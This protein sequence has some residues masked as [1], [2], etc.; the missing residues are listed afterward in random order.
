MTESVDRASGHEGQANRPTATR[1]TWTQIDWRNA[2]RNVQHLQQ[3]IFRAAQQKD[4]QKV[5]HL[6]RLLLKSHSNLVVS[7]RQI[8]Q[9]NAGKATPGVDGE[10]ALD[11]QTR[12]RLVNELS[13]TQY[14]KAKPVRR[15]YIPKAKGGKRPLGIPTIRDRI[16]QNVVK[17]AYEP[18]FETEFEANSFGFRPGRSAWDAQEEVHAALNASA[19]GQ[20]QYILDAD[21]KGAF[22]HISH[23]FILTRIGQLPGRHW[24]K[25]WLKAGYM[26][27]GKLHQTEEGTPQGGVISPLLA[28][29]AL[30]GL[31]AHL[32]KGYRYVRYADDFV[33]MT[34]TREA[35]EQARPKITAFL[36]ERGLELNEEKTRIVHKTDGFEFLGFHI[37]DRNGKL[38]ITPPK[39][40]IK[41]LHRKVKETLKQ[42]L[43]ASPETVIRTLNPILQGWANYYS[44]CVAKRTYSEITNRVWSILV[45]WMRRRHPNKS[46]SW[47]RRKYLTTQ[48]DRHHVFFANVQT[49]RGR[50]RRITL[51]NVADTPIVRHIKVKGTNSPFDP[52]LRQYWQA[53]AERLAS[54]RL[55]RRQRERLIAQAQNWRCEV[56]GD[57]LGNGEPLELH[58]RKPVS[59]NGT[60]EVGNLV[61]LHAACHQNMTT[62]NRVTLRQTA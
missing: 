12:E 3:R 59:Q 32:G 6:C 42:L 9:V 57:W 15:V 27:V 17:N 22:D 31:Q 62:K 41:A 52:T 26:E 39:E 46:W 35:L 11:S 51:V 5:K 61:W 8:T 55:L 29:I 50:T 60:D 49:R 33:V 53:R 2:R 7:V 28:N 20:N 4:W 36:A 47:I 19:A 58:H 14:W 45:R 34:K 21:I 30:D 48:G 40:K 13:Q 44:T 54:I 1:I 18:I 56:C 25:Q 10:V 43:H 24:V 23:D 37:Q 16:L 38:L